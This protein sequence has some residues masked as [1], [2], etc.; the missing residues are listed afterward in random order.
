MANFYKI[1]QIYNKE[2]AVVAFDLTIIKKKLYNLH[3]LFFKTTEVDLKIT[4]IKV[5]FNN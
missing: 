5:N 1:S 4:T 2:M 3:S